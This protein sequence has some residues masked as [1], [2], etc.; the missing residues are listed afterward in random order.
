M[1]WP[2][3]VA[4]HCEK[5]WPTSSKVSKLVRS[6]CPRV[7]PDTPAAVSSR[8]EGT[9][10]LGKLSAVR[11]VQLPLAGCTGKQRILVKALAEVPRSSSG[12]KE[13]ADEQGSVV[14]VSFNGNTQEMEIEP[15][16][17]LEVR[18]NCFTVSLIVGRGMCSRSSLHPSF[19]PFKGPGQT[20]H[21]S[22]CCARQQDVCFLSGF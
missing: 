18:F 5:Q 6:T 11:S 20:S 13:M 14:K 1:P 8:R 2:A 22:C 17:G 10:E 16:L 9:R 3:L 21:M 7:C 12:Q 4:H 15:E 19:S